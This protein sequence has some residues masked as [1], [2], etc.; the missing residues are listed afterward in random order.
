[1]GSRSALVTACLLVCVGAGS[2]VLGNDSERPVL[3]VDPIWDA[4]S[5]ELFTPSTCSGAGVASMTW[6]IQDEKGKTLSEA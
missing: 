5:S 6:A 1:M 3:A 4:S 2:C